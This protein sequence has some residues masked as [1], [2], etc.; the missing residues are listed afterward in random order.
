MHYEATQFAMT[1]TNQN[2]V[3]RA[4]SYPIGCE[5]LSDNTND[6]NDAPLVDKEKYFS[7]IRYNRPTWSRRLFLSSVFYSK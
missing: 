2:E 7:R 5:M 3:G 1:A 6:I 4:L